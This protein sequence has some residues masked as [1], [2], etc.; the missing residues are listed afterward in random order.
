MHGPPEKM[1]LEIC[2]TCLAPQGCPVE[3]FETCGKNRDGVELKLT[4][5][6]AWIVRASITIGYSHRNAVLTICRHDIDIQITADLRYRQMDLKLDSSFERV[7]LH[8]LMSYLLFYHQ[9]FSSL[10]VK[11]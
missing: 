3:M 9:S 5:L 7:Y 8:G 10:S 11:Q 6:R 1:G 4:R 2:S